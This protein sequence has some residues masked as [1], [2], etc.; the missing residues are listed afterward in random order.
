MQTDEPA[1]GRHEFRYDLFSHRDTVRVGGGSGILHA[2]NWG[3]EYEPTARKA[4]M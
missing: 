3:T 1:K 2:L 4:R